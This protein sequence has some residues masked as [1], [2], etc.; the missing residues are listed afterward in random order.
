MKTAKLLLGALICI[1]LW[2]ST[3]QGQSENRR[4]VKPVYIPGVVAAEGTNNSANNKQPIS[5]V[6]TTR[7]TTKPATSK[8][9]VLP[10]SN[11]SPA[12]I[13][14]VPGL[15]Y[16]GCNGDTGCGSGCGSGCGCDD[17]VGRSFFGRVGARSPIRVN[18]TTD[19]PEC[20]CGAESD[21][22]CQCDG[23]TGLRRFLPTIRVRT[24]ACNKYISV[25]G[26]YVDLE[27]FDGDGGGGMS[28]L[29]SFN[30]GWSIGFARGR[31]FP[32]GLRLE[33]ETTLRH[34]TVDEYSQGNFVGMDFVPTATFDSIDSLY[35][36]SSLTNLL[37]DFRGFGPRTVPY[38]G[39]GLGSIFV[40]GD[41]VTP[42]LGRTDYIDDGA[43]AYQFIV[44]VTRKINCRME[45]YTEFR[46]FGTSGL[47][48][49]TDTNMAGPDLDGEFDYQSNNVVFGLRYT[50]PNS[51]GK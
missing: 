47:D 30:D 37:Q 44:G 39:F 19:E 27:D 29:I 1:S 15:S 35:S 40:D 3:A 25:F 49:E 33:S 38:V 16:S 9:N 12:P 32:G 6:K 50:I 5:K 14:A 28:R 23:R 45:A 13:Q 11:A 10:A 43:F 26:G 24:N 51:R 21:C 36:V 18:F 17:Q 2:A 8:S 7:S 46:H 20:E 4:G 22:C 48:V 42:G 34:N 31:R 41:I